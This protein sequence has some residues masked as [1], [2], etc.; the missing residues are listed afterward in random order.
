MRKNTNNESLWALVSN[1]L[2]RIALEER[3]EA[4]LAYKLKQN[5]AKTQKKV[6]VIKDMQKFI[7]KI[8][9]KIDQKLNQ[10]LKYFTV[11]RHNRSNEGSRL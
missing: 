7:Q 2:K 9:Q 11:M 4:R 8:D 10:V 3:R 6:T 1:D 5:C